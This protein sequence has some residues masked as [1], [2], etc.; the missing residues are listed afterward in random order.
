MTIYDIIDLFLYAAMIFDLGWKTFKMSRIKKKMPK[1][2]R[3]YS[4]PTIK[5]ILYIAIVTANI[6]YVA[7]RLYCI[8]ALNIYTFSAIAVI[9]PVALY[10]VILDYTIGG[11][12]FNQKSIYYKQNLIY[13]GEI[14]R[15]F[16]DHNE[17][18]YDYTITF[19]EK[20]SGEREL[21]IRIKD[22]EKAYPLLMS[23]PFEELDR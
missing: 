15:S 4:F 17:G 22:E 7:Y 6:V 5:K 13:F 8:I 3:Y 18:Y 9:L 16:R 10:Y 1:W 23:I 21:N 19:K 20:D 2:K 12:Y 14:I 11:I